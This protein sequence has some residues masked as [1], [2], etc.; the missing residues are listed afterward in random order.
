MG[1]MGKIVKHLIERIERLDKHIIFIRDNWPI[2]YKFKFKE[3]NELLLAMED[4]RG[5]NRSYY[6]E[7]E[8]DLMEQYNLK[9]REDL[10][11][12]MTK[13]ENKELSELHEEI[14]FGNKII[15]K[16]SASKIMFDSCIP[17]PKQL[18]KSILKLIDK[19]K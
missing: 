8:R 2:N 10:L 17:D 16:L 13:D 15:D 5:L 3:V 12:I 14:I 7:F 11:S 18:P 4:R 1:E 9:N 6:N 19:E